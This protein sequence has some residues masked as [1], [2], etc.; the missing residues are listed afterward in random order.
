MRVVGR[1]L[2]DESARSRDSDGANDILLLSVGVPTQVPSHVA[3][4]FLLRI[5]SASVEAR[6]DVR[7]VGVVDDCIAHRPTKLNLEV[8]GLATGISE[9]KIYPQVILFGIVGR[10][11]ERKVEPVEQTLYLD[12]D[13]VGAG[14]LREFRRR[15]L[16][17]HGAVSV[18]R[19]RGVQRQPYCSRRYNGTCHRQEDPFQGR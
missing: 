19:R 9:E 18:D 8:N 16:S 2:V 7:K 12:A 3:E 15:L 5:D 6:H 1:G 11:F 4:K 13:V 14:L 10:V 17:H